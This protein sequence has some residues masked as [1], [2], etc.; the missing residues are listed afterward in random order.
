MTRVL[1]L[2]ELLQKSA[3]NRRSWVNRAV[4]RIAQMPADTPKTSEKAP[5]RARKAKKVSK[6][7][8]SAGEAL[9]AQQL[10]NSGITGWEA[11]YRFHPGR[12]WRL[13]FGWPIARVAVE[14][15][16]AIW[17]QGRHSRGKGMESDME[18]YNELAK[19]GWRLLRFSPEMVAKGVAI[20]DVK[21][22][23]EMCE[24]SL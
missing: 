8:P 19:L 24:W 5:P 15:E 2:S 18:K 13:D 17:T 22:T 16:G 6:A 3:A 7:Q 11:E 10:R 9:F 4:K 21:L 1:T 23:L 14:I 12:R 20:A